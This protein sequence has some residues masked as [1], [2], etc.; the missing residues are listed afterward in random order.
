MELAGPWLDVTDDLPADSPFTLARADGIGVFQFSSGLYRGG[1]IPAAGV[2]V[3]RQM[4]LSFGKE[5]GLGEPADVRVHQGG[6][7]SV[8]GSFRK[9]NHIRAWYIT[10][11]LSFIF[12]SHTS[13]S[14]ATE[15]LAQ[16]EAMVRSIEFGK[17]RANQ[18]PLPTPG[19]RPVS[20]HDQVPGAADL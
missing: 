12:A 9:G 15:E 8:G 13:G 16:C 5:K 18:P 14:A 6:A 4:L 19:S 1:D 11:G 7:N 2:D 10:D 20:N 3:L 17:N